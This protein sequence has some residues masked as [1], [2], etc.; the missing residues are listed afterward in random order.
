MSTWPAQS[1]PLRDG[2]A[3]RPSEKWVVVLDQFE[4]WLQAHSGETDAEL[5]RALRQCD[6]R[7]VQAVVVVRDDFWMAV[8][9]FLRAIDV[10]LVQ[11]GNAAAVELFDIRHT[12]RVLEAFGQAMGQLKGEGLAGEGDAALFLDEAARGLAGPDA[13]V[14][15]ARLSLFA[16]V[17]RNRPWTRATISDLDGIDGIGVKFLDDCFASAPYKRHRNAAQALLKELLPPTASV[18]RGSPRTGSELRAA[19]HYTDQPADFAELIRM[20]DGELKLITAVDRDGSAQ[21][22]S[23][24]ASLPAG[25]AEETRYQ[26]AHDYLVR[27][28]R[29]WYQRDQGSSRKGRAKLRLALITASWMEHPSPRQLPS[30]F[31]LASILWQIPDGGMVAQRAAA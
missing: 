29:K 30:M 14:I 1:R 7:R 6:G 19:A 26:I 17:V 25:A 28:I 2:A 20:L 31:E 16:L 5:V 12:R 10:P 22:L 9:R 4:Q 27:P 8:T 23:G 11:G 15:P 21:A 24:R 3:R 18:I 13:R